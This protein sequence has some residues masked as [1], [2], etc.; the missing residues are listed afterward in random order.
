[1]GTD[2][3]VTSGRWPGLNS[4]VTASLGGT[5]HRDVSPAVGRNKLGKVLWFKSLWRLLES[6][7]WELLPSQDEM[8]SRCSSPT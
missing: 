8:L 2:S 6:R 7:C 1:M 3:G 5:P 4:S